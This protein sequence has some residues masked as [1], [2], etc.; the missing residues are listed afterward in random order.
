MTFDQPQT[1]RKT[2]IHTT[3]LYL[4]TNG[5]ANSAEISV[6]IPY[7]TGDISLSIHKAGSSNHI[8]GPNGWQS[9][10]YW[11]NGTPSEVSNDNVAWFSLPAQLVEHITYSNYSIFCKRESNSTSTRTILM[12]G[13]LVARPSHVNA[14]KG[15]IELPPLP[16]GFSQATLGSLVAIDNKTEAITSEDPAFK[17]SATH[18]AN[19]IGN[20]PQSGPAH[21]PVPE[22]AAVKSEALEPPVAEPEVQA[23]KPEQV[24][25]PPED[26]SRAVF[27]APMPKQPPSSTTQNPRSNSNLPILLGVVVAILLAFAVYFFAFRG[28][29]SY[30]ASKNAQPSAPAKKPDS[31]PAPPVQNAPEPELAKREAEP[32]KP[33]PEPGNKVNKPSAPEVKKSPQKLPT[34]T[35]VESPKPAPT[36]EKVQP[37]AP[38]VPDL[39]RMVNEALKR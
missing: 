6:E 24:P 21:D 38:S 31:P 16:S 36:P 23:T 8:L 34:T 25:T 9:A 17:D 12:G 28:S 37:P 20:K 4:P 3:K 33:A 35:P 22:V 19:L 26:S 27:D 1:R 7:G 13:A 10:D 29:P 2:K 18:T 11:F 14:P 30:D 15:D 5:E 32:A 39:N